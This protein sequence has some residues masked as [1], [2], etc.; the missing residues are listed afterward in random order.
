M[1]T[2]GG[3]LLAALAGVQQVHREVAALLQNA[4][5]YLVQQ[6]L[7]GERSARTT[8]DASKA[9]DHPE[10]WTPSFA[11]RFFHLKDPTVIALVSVCLTERP[12]D[13]FVRP[14]TEPLVTAGWARFPEPVPDR[15][16]A[17]WWGKMPHWTD[18]ARDGTEARWAAERGVADWSGSLEQVCFMLPLVEIDGSKTLVAR[19]LDP[20]VRSLPTS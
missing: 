6:G 16:S 20:M 7:R 5:Q 3:A 17:W 10:A 2:D 18:H 4:D 12:R 9:W 19:L 13:T 1:T 8:S 14:F 11:A 15:W